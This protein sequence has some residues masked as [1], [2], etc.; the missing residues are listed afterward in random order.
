MAYKDYLIKKD[1]AKD[2]FEIL[3]SKYTIFAPKR[4]TR[5]GR[6]CDMD[7]IMYE[8]IKSFDELEYKEKSTYSAKEALLPMTENLFYFTEDDYTETKNPYKKEVLVFA[9]ACDINAIKYLDDMFVK[10]GPFEDMFYLRRKNKVH[11]A[12]LECQED[13]DRNCFCVSC[14]S[15][16]TDDF[17]YA[18]R[19]NDDGSIKVKTE[20]DLDLSKFS[21]EE[22]DLKF[23]E[24]NK[25][26]VNFPEIK[27]NEEANRIANSDIWDEYNLRCIGCG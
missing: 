3:K 17:T 11:Y 21:I 25:L 26:K 16:K 19:F 8:N 12:L 23:P 20:D 14:D 24:E 27:D 2:L 22:F 4:I 6:Y 7:T 15:N 5:G 9:R 18:F 1:E 10:N 13:L